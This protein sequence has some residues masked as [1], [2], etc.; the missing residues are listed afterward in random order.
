[1]TT[2]TFQLIQLTIAEANKLFSRNICDQ[3]GRQQPE[4]HFA[5]SVED[6]R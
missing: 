4:T 2:E 5:P 1:M 6:G 3:D